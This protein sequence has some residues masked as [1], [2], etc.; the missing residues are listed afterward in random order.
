MKE[1]LGEFA[2]TQIE[3]YKRAMEDW[4]KVRSS[5]GTIICCFD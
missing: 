3:M 5:R 2:D 1:L 4:D